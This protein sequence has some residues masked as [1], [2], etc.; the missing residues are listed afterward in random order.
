[1]DLN[2]NIQTGQLINTKKRIVKVKA[3]VYETI[4]ITIMNNRIVD[5]KFIMSFTDQLSKFTGIR[6]TYVQGYADS[7]SIVVTQNIPMPFTLLMLEAEI[8]F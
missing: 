5:R 6:E 4:G 1:M 2:T 8:K 7:H 3:F